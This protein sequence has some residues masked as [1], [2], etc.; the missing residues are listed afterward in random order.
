MINKNLSEEL[1]Q[2]LE[3][4]KIAIEG[5]LKK[6][7][8]KDDKLEGDWDTRFPNFNAGQGSSGLET[9]A[10][11]VEEYT[12][13][14]PIEHNL[15]TTLINI[16]SALEKIKNNTYGICE[17]CKKEIPIERLKVSPESKF[18]LKCNEE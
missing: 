7:A 6:F 4:K 15:E 10:D 11:E 14:L 5:Q 3:K 12:T 18:C 13:L 16:N 2:I 1:K 17:K 9:A 8:K